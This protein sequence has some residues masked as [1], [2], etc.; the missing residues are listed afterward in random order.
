MGDAERLLAMDFGS[1]PSCSDS[2]QLNATE[3]VTNARQGAISDV[4]T[5]RKTI[6][7]VPSAGPLKSLPPQEEYTL[8]SE[9]TYLCN[10]S[11]TAGG[12]AIASQIFVWS[13]DSALGAA[14]DQAQ[15]AAKRVARESSAQVHL[16]RQGHEPPAFLQTIG[17]ILVSRRG[18]RE[19]AP[20]QYMLC[21][22][23]HLGHITFDEVD[24]G[25]AALCSGFVFLISYPITLQQTKLYL[26]KGSSCSTEEI[27]AARLAAM[28]LSETGE[29]IEVDD[30]AEFASFLKIFGRGTMKS[31]IPKTG[32]LW[33]Q[34]ALAPELFEPKLF[35]IQQVSPKGGMFAGMFRRPSWNYS[36]SRSPSRDGPEVRVEARHISP[37]TQSDLEAEGIYLLDAFGEL[38]VI[39]G[40]LFASQSET[41]RNALLG[42]TLLLT[43]D[44]SSVTAAERPCAPKGSVLFGGV[45]RDMK[46]L[47]RHWDDGRGLWGTAGLMAG[48]SANTG[49]D[50]RIVPLEDVLRAVCRN[51]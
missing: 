6:Q 45:P 7:E 13:G 26:W 17:G 5:V 18:A 20:K 24:F 15:A 27:S 3:V 40:P 41:V 36:P 12:K 23:K 39:I 33:R 31:S 2:L 9:S 14:R 42:Q 29:I 35:K 32:D 8:F 46:M 30:G 16:V 37:F 28:D 19:G 22:R 48:S 21:G 4:R 43:S 25:I 34:K 1:V 49:R 44:Y 10:H 38:Y 51:G 11:Y 50:V 47:F